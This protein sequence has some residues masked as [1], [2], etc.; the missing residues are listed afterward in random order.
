ML[1]VFRL[2]YWFR[3]SLF[4]CDLS[5]PQPF[6][7]IRYEVR[8]HNRLPNDRKDYAPLIIDGYQL[9]YPVYPG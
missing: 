7:E 6:Y 3:L 5:I 8:N 9:A 4:G 1:I 2:G